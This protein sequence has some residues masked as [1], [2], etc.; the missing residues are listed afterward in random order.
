M[1]QRTSNI[2]IFGLALA[3]FAPASALADD[4]PP[5]PFP[6]ADNQ[7][8]LLYSESGYA[9]TGTA[10]TMGIQMGSQ[11]V[12]SQGE[13]AG[14]F[15][16]NNDRIVV[17]NPDH[18]CLLGDAP[19]SGNSCDFISTAIRQEDEHHISW[20]FRNWGARCVIRLRYTKYA[21]IDVPRWTE[22]QPW[23]NGKHFIVV[24]P[25]AARSATVFGKLG[26]A[27]VFMTPS[28]PLSA[29]DSKRFRL[30][31]SKVIPSI[32]TVYEIE[33]LTAPH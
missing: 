8:H 23:N 24:V 16:N 9:S 26:G 17:A 18:D 2:V 6:T 13:Q 1:I 14:T 20:K 22:F 11:T 33:V 21:A 29:D 3:L 19:A 32:A 25:T 27:N 15:T 12:S 7:W 28:D 30:V 31:A 10:E 4:V 5:P